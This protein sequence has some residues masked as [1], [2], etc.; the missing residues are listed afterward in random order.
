MK[1]ID[2][3]TNKEITNP[4][5]TKGICR[6]TVW[7]SPEAYA[8]IDDVTKFALSEDDYETVQ[9]Y[10]VWTDEEI[11]AKEQSAKEAE[12]RELMDALPDAVSDLSEV[13]STD[14]ENVG[15]IMDAIAELS[16]TVSELAGKG[17]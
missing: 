1:I 2:E 8:S 14:S 17:E 5:L 11:A 13:V 4:D 16:E 3:L 6:E 12:K 9:M 15:V 7:A 10:H